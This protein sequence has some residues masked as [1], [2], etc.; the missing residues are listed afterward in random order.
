MFGWVGKFFNFRSHEALALRRYE[1]AK[2]TRL[3]STQWND[4]A[5]KPINDDLP[6]D[7]ETIRGRCAKEYGR[8]GFV[9]GVVRTHVTDLVGEDGPTLQVISDNAT[10]NEAF[11]AGWRSWWA[12]PDAAGKWSGV[13]LLKIW[14]KSLWLCGEYLVQKVTRNNAA[15]PVKLR[16]NT[17]AAR[18]LRTPFGREGQASI[19]MGIEVDSDGRPVRYHFEK[20]LPG[21]LLA[22]S[23][24]TVPVDAGNVLHHFEADEAGQLRGVPWVQPS[25]QPS[26]DLRDYD[27]QVL[28]AARV[29]A[30]FAVALYTEHPDARYI[31]VNESVE[32]E[33][34]CYSTL[35]PGWKPLALTPPQPATNYVEFREERLREIGRPVGMPL[36]K[37]RCDASGS[38]YSSARFDDQQY[39]SHL[40]AVQGSIE[41][42]T[43]T[44]L[45]LDV[46]RE[47]ELSGAIPQRP[48]KI[49]IAWTW[50]ARPNV[51]P[52]KEAQALLIELVETK[53]LS[54]GDAC[55]KL[56]RD[57]DAVLADI[58]RWTNTFIDKG[59]VPPWA[60]P[61]PAANA[62]EDTAVKK[63]EVKRWISEALEERGVTW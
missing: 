50:P 32:V 43:L 41:R 60:Q 11:E 22:S 6:G 57:P 2:T 4:A 45:A 8:N 5:D 17:I 46:A 62:T 58:E 3:N 54:F 38:N 55:K 23:L 36:L 34:R 33:R 14:I 16:L 44:P 28:D 35:P 10:Y 49:T 1:S 25:L 37:I 24:E 29:A 53:T 51:D 26:A 30:D 20:Y 59:I 27:D 21:E 7:L 61:D 42:S 39:S 31:E 19:F 48:D 52:E 63:A 9:Q 13:D 12:A 18:R 15:G 47:L 56:G 40:R